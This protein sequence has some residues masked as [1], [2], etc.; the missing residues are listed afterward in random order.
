MVEIQIQKE[1]EDGLYED[2]ESGNV[3]PSDC[4]VCFESSTTSIH[5]TN[6]KCSFLVCDTCRRRLTT[7]PQCQYDIIIPQVSLVC[8]AEQEEQLNSR[9]NDLSQ[10]LVFRL[11]NNTRETTSDSCCV[12]KY[13]CL[14]LLFIIV[15]E[16]FNHIFIT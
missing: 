1:S 8:I 10:R 16:T 3:T 4:S 14:V 6:V 7:C 11:Q 12:S 15:S 5:C 13:M 2:L 9:T